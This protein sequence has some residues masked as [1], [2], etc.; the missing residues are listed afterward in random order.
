MDASN[1]VSVEGASGVAASSLARSQFSMRNLLYCSSHRSC[2]RVDISGGQAYPFNNGARSFSNAQGSSMG[3]LELE[4]RGYY[5]GYNTTITCNDDDT[6]D[7][8]C[9]GNGCYGLFLNCMSG[10]NRGVFLNYK[11]LTLY[12]SKTTTECFWW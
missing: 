11:S 5:A 7:V 6:C 9:Y 2:D 3:D 10:A 1:V 12:T 8:K 4:F